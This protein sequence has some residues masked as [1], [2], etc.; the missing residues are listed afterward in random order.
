MYEIQPYTKYRARLLG[1]QIQLSDKRYK[2]IDVYKNNK[3]I[4][5]IGD[6]R[7]SDYPTY[8]KTHGLEYANERRRLYRLRHKND[9]ITGYYAKNLLW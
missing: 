8:I 6:T 3:Y 7:Y 4:T 2:K 9:G 5:S 1:V